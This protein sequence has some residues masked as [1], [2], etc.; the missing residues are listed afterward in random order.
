MKVDPEAMC[1][2]WKEFAY[3]TLKPE[4][5]CAHLETLSEWSNSKPKTIRHMTAEELAN[6][7]Q[8]TIDAL[9]VQ[10]STRECAQELS[11][12]ITGAESTTTGK[13]EKS[14]EHLLLDHSALPISTGNDHLVIPAQ[15]STK[16]R[17]WDGGQYIA[18]HTSRT[19]CVRNG[20]GKM[21]ES[22]KTPFD[23]LLDQI[24]LIVR[25]EVAAAYMTA[26]NYT[27][28]SDPLLT[29]NEAAT[30]MGVT[31]RW[32]YRHADRLPFVR[33]LSRKELRIDQNGMRRWLATKKPSTR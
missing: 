18:R 23:A 31:S 6:L 8:E 30:L 27:M 21:S 13:C 4:V 25:E 19:R 17:W 2:A 10:G 22:A 1:K 12:H 11:A 3:T 20:P 9:V 26:S 16:F 28:E 33:R 5:V 7:R 24:R 29:V 14:A 15:Y 32:I